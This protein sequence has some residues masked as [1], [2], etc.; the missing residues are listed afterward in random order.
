[1]TKPNP[2]ESSLGI[3]IMIGIIIFLSLMDIIT[4]LINGLMFT[5][6]E[7]N[8]IFNFGGGVWPLIL[9]TIAWIGIFWFAYRR[10]FV[11]ARF[12][13]CTAFVWHVLLRIYAI[14]AN[15]TAFFAVKAA[16]PE[17]A[18]QII[19]ATRQVAVEVKTQ[20]YFTLVLA[21]VMPILLNIIAYALFCIDHKVKK[22]MR[23]EKE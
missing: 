16:S 21:V 5:H 20:D 4:A 12:V 15:L 1:M 13:L 17:V 22:R 9:V 8:P 2:K 18:Y 11:G 6:G 23:R 10:L 19:N 3:K 14:K 7:T